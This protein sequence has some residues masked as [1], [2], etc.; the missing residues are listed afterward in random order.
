MGTLAIGLRRNLHIRAWA[1]LLNAWRVQFQMS[2][3]ENSH[4]ELLSSIRGDNVDF[5]EALA[6]ENEGDIEAEH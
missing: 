4:G 6:S 3:A 1:Q 5:A 2:M